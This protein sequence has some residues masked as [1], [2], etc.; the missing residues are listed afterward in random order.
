M[1]PK[2]LRFRDVRTCVRACVLRRR[3]SLAGLTSTSSCY[4]PTSLWSLFSLSSYLCLY[5]CVFVLLPFFRRIKIIVSMR[6]LNLIGFLSPHKQRTPL[7]THSKFIKELLSF[8]FLSRF[9]AVRFFILP[10]FLFTP[11][12]L[13]TSPES[14]LKA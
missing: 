4:R 2:V 1:G 5:C 8:K 3:H 9:S 10:T 13:I 6:Y 14:L 12:S 7:T 11:I